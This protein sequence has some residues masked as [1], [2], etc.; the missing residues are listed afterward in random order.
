VCTNSGSEKKQLAFDLERARRETPGCRDTLHFNNAGA[1][2]IPQPVTEATIAH[3]RLEAQIGGYEAAEQAHDAIEHT[4]DAVS[5]L[6]GCA[7][8]EVAIVENV[9]RAW[10]MAFY[11]LL[12]KPGDRILTAMAEYASTSTCR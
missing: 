4:Y 5:T 8:D 12:F 1:S 9:T 11:S 6:I 7:R 2:L 10:D 3:L